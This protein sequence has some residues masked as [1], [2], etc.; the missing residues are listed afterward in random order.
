MFYVPGAHPLGLKTFS[1]NTH[2]ENTYS[3][4]ALMEN[5]LLE[6]TFL[7]N[8]VSEIDMSLHYSDQMSQRSQVSRVTL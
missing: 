1:G 5:T 4:S 6:N 3:D 7:T 8:T 2:S